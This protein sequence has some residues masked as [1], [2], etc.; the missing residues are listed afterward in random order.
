MMRLFIG[1]ELP[2]FIQKDLSCL[3]SGLKEVRWVEEHNMHITLAFIGE[4]E[5]GA[6]EELH[7]ALCDISFDPFDLHLGEVDCFDSR[8]KPKTIWAGVKG[9]V[10][11]LVHLHQKVLTAIESAGLEPERR[12]YKPHVTIARARRDSPKEQ[13]LSYMESHNGLKTDRFTISHFSLYRSHLTRH[14]ADYEV[15][16]R[17]G[18]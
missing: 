5:E 16:E 14:G 2:D 7:H 15:L 11:P 13:L 6:A 4:V 3:C 10:D 12:K 18:G 1:L 9:D 8:G 17:Y